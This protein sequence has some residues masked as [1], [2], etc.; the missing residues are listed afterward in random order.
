[1]ALS[2][3]AF[4]EGESGELADMTPRLSD[5]QSLTFVEDGKVDAVPFAT[6]ASQVIVKQISPLPSFH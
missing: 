5:R 2:P 6:M 1:M 4:V 3:S